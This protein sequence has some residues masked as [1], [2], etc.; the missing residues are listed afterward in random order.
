MAK[1]DASHRYSQQA[2]EKTERAFKLSVSVALIVLAVVAFTAWWWLL[3]IVPVA[4][5]WFQVYTRKLP[6]AEL[7]DVTA[8]TF[9]SVPRAQWQE[10]KAA[11]PEAVVKPGADQ[12]E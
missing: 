7:L 10:F 4:L 6:T 1:L 3:V 12:D 9:V 5:I 8:N 11:H 2:G